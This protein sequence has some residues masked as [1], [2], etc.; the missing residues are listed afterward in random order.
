MS[1]TDVGYRSPYG[2]KAKCISLWIS[3]VKTGKHIKKGSGGFREKG[4]KIK[5]YF[6]YHDFILNSQEL[7][8]AKILDK[9]N[10]KWERN[11]KGFEYLTLNNEKRKY[12]PDFYLFDYNFY[13][14]Y[15]GWVTEE[16]NHK[17][18][19]AKERNHLNLLVIYSQDRRYK[20]LGLN[21]E[22]IENEPDIILKNIG[23]YQPELQI[24]SN[25]IG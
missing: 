8:V 17:M 13:V 2:T 14:E 25:V 11:L 19:D 10:L 18:K 16:I 12:Y 5:V 1:K 21:L 22:Q 9:L 4:G 24:Q 3:K 15:K 6:K 20:K 23:A 7:R